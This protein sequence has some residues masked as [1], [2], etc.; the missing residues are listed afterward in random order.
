VNA[1][2]KL[3]HLELIM[4]ARNASC[5]QPEDYNGPALLPGWQ[6]MGGDSVLIN[7]R[8][9]NGALEMQPVPG[10]PAPPLQVAAIGGK[11][12]RSLDHV[13]VT[14]PLVLDC[15]HTKITDPG[16]LTDRC[17]ASNAS[18]A[19]Q[20]IH[21]VYA[22]DV[23][24]A[25]SQ[26]NLTGVWGDNYAMTYYLHQV[27]DTVWWFGMGPFRNGSF[28]QVFQGVATNGTIAGSWQD[29]PL[30]T[31]AGG[32]PLQLSID[33]TRMLLTPISSASLGDRRWWKLYDA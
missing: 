23:I 28:A 26:E 1:N 29:V 31:G 13:R 3:L 32:E 24:D 4:F 9:L 18:Y 12:I 6:E 5:A 27:G 25:T 33:P 30:G 11:A 10:H 14:G 8:P 19:N 17:Q 2:R 20:E 21:P 15:G 16:T 22:I 7:G